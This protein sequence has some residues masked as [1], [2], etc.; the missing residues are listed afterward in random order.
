MACLH[1]WPP[2]SSAEMH[3][4][5]HTEKKKTRTH[6]VRVKNRARESLVAAA[7]EAS[8]HVLVGL[9]GE[10]DLPPPAFDT[11]TLGFPLTSSP[12]LLPF[13]VC[14]LCVLGAVH[15]RVW[16]VC[17]CIFVRG[18]H[19]GHFSSHYEKN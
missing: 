15:V 10:S 17:A 12:E 16:C 1:P 2:R 5:T 11:Q 6:T 7:A 8:K 14:Q 3:A 19:R 13:L 18:K 9:S 4:H